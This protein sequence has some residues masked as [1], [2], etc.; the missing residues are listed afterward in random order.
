MVQLLIS[1]NGVSH[2][3]V[4]LHLYGGVLHKVIAFLG[5]S[6]DRLIILFVHSTVGCR[7]D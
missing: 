5:R 2:N 1:V 6:G 4:V 3:L 7:E